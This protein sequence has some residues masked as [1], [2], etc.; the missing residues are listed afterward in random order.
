MVDCK[1]LVDEWRRVS[2]RIARLVKVT[3]VEPSKELKLLRFRYRRLYEK[4]VESGC[5]GEVLGNGEDLH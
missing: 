4:I 2:K 5:L 1:G 3:D